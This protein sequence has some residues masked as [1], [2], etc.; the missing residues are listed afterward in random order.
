MEWFPWCEEA[1]EKARKEDKPVFLSIGYSSCHWCHVMKRESFQDKEVA[2][3]INETFVSIKVDK[4]ERP[5]IDSVYMDVA[6]SMT[7]R[8]GWPLTILMTPEKIPFYAGTYI[9]KVG[10]RG[11]SGLMELIPKI[12]ELWEKDRE[13]LVERGESIIENLGKEDF[14]KDKPID[15]S[16][17]D[18]AFDYLYS[19]Y[20][21]EYGGFGRNQK[22]P[23]PQNFLFLLRCNNGKKKD[24][25]VEMVRKTLKEM[26][27]GGIYDHLG[28]GFHRYS[29]DREWILPHFEK[30]LYDQAMLLLAY[31]EAS[32]ITKDGL[33]HKTVEEVIRY[34]DRNLKSEA[35]GFFSSEDAESSG[36]EG[37]YYTWQKKEIE[38]ILKED[39]E[40]FVEMFNVAEEGNFKDEATNRKTGEN[41]LYLEDT[42]EEFVDNRNISLEDIKSMKKKLFEK[43]LKREKPKIDNK[44]LTDW[45]SLMITA[46]SRAGFVLNEDRWLDMAEETAY[47]ILEKM[48]SDGELYH[49]HIDGEVSIK[50]GLDDHSFLVWAL[51]NLYQTTFKIEYLK[52]AIYL[53]DMM[54][55]NFWDEVNGG[56]FISRKDEDELPINKKEVYDG[57]Y[58]SGNSISLLDLVLLS[59][60]TGDEK[61]DDAVKQI[62]GT[63]GGRI[64]ENPGQFTMFLTA[65]QSWWSGGKEIVMVG[66]RNELEDFID[67][68]RK[69]FLPDLVLIVKNKENEEKLD[70]LIEFTSSME[71]VDDKATIYFCENFSCE[72][73]ITDVEKF[74]EFLEKS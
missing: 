31:T 48:I 43:R 32:Q 50:A 17:L 3:L 35:G 13:R 8:G 10:K 63:F 38:E 26:R 46:L 11:M 19:A 16:I 40:V 52:K 28:Y 2:E 30:M 22:F 20:D 4:E 74:E 7:G 62:I 18:E 14:V 15:G 9:P 25:S 23:S 47:F 73:P 67:V 37:A 59:Q 42:V 33:Y 56:F 21:S 12:E 58:P 51:L 54:F 5:A 34:V 27:K 65:L 55:K 6:R 70:E 57:A 45:N 71:K 64:S 39:S 69:E 49:A 29:T 36:K 72:K 1:F 24:E 60:I 68:L 66:E 44:I 53:T 41:V 61:Y